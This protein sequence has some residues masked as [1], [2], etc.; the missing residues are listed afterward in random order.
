[1]SVT[2]NKIIVLK[3]KKKDY[4]EKRK[5]QVAPIKPLMRRVETDYEI[6][7]LEVTFKFIIK[8]LLLLVSRELKC[9]GQIP[10][11]I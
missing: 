5:G 10:R 4:L 2:S 11:E 1:M 8:T 7:E 3:L 6:F 9:L